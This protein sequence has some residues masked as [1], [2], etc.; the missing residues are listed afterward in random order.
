LNIYNFDGSLIQAIGMSS[1][2]TN[3]DEKSD[4][5]WVLNMGKFTSTDSPTGNLSRISKKNG[6]GKYNSVEV[7]INSLQR[8][9]DVAYA[10]FDQDG[11]EDVV[12]A[13]FGNWT[14]RL[15]WFENKGEKQYNR[16]TSIPITGAE[17]VMVDDLNA[18]GLPDIL[19]MIA[20]G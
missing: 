9:C 12:I 16:H 2:A 7:L 8:P 17:E 11:D 19:A 3:I 4:G 6:S 20:Q 1:P 18:D 15:E 13:Q 14:G 5:L 10:D